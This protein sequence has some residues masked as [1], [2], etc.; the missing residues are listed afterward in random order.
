MTRI[1]KTTTPYKVL[2]DPG[3]LSRL[4]E[5]TAGILGRAKVCLVTDE[6]VNL[7][8][9]V[10]VHQALEDAGLET[11]KIVFPPGERTKSLTSVSLLLDFLAEHEFTRTDGIVALGGGVIGDLS[12]FAA[13]IYLRGIRYIQVPTTFLA[14]ADSSVGGKTG[15]NLGSGK[16]LA[17]TFWQPSL[18]LFDSETMETLDESAL[19]DGLAETVKCGIIG[20]PGLF[21]YLQEFPWDGMPRGPRLH[22]FV[23]RCVDGAIGVKQRMVEE[24]ERDQGCRQYLNL[25]HTLGHAIELASR[26]TVSH[27]HGVAMGMVLIARIAAR[28]GWSEEDCLTPLLALLTK[29]GFPLDVPYQARSLAEAALLDKKRKGGLIHLVVPVRIGEC[30]LMPVPAEDLEKL[31]EMGLSQ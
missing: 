18:V 17:G 15:V 31:I 21:A 5:E 6:R 19:L 11:H 27:G 29:F 10:R 14:A 4:G 22:Q 25:G 30:R 24:D 20:D 16:N 9:G 13:S 26:Y 7:L 23:D 2:S 1:I 12:G 8:Y 3:V 28:M